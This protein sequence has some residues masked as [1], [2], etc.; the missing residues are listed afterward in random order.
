M[1]ETLLILFAIGSLGLLGLAAFLAW[2]YVLWRD[3]R[4]ARLARLRVRP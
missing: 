3:L 4:A 2:G 1:S